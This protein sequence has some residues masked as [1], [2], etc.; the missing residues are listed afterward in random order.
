MSTSA[1]TPGVVTSTT[2]VPPTSGTTVIPTSVETTTIC[3]KDMA[4]VGGVH[5]SSVHYSVQ[6]V[7]QIDN[8]KLTSATGDGVSFPLV[9]GTTGLFD[10]NKKPI[11]Y[12]DITF[13]PAGVDSLSSIIVSGESNVDKF[14]VEFF[15]ASNPNEPVLL[16]PGTTLS[17]TSRIQNSE[18]VISDFP[19]MVPSPLSG[20]R[21]NILS[22][23]Y[24]E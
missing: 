18:A 7:G 19:A 1:T 12:I 14:D 24:D 6:P 17:Y 4:Q 3:Q 11:Y 10:R 23:K 9:P 21:I 5:V 13:N 15:V 16:S 20:I 22:I 8:A 2:P